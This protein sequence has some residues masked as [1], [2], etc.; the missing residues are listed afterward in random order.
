MSGAS[1]SFDQAR[2]GADGDSVFAPFDAPPATGSIQDQGRFTGVPTAIFGFIAFSVIA[3]LVVALAITPG[4]AVLQIGTAA[5]TSLF[6][7]LPSYIDV[8]RL[9]QRNRIFANS[10]TGP[11]QIATVYNQ[12]RQEAS[13][14]QVS[15]YLKAAAIDG[16]DKDFYQHGGVDVPSLVRAAV[17]N[18][19]AG[20]IQSGASTIAMQVVRNVQVQQSLQLKTAAEQQA[21]YKAA[22]SDTLSRKLK[23]MKLAIGL[24]KTYSKKEILLAYL[25]IANFGHANYGVEAAAQAYFSTTAASLTP[26]QAASII[27]IVQSPSARNLGTPSDYAAN[28]VRRNFILRQMHDDGDITAAQ[29][30]TALATKVDASFVHTSIVSDSCLQ[31]PVDFRWMCDYVVHDVPDI[32]AFGSTKAQRLANWKLGGYDVYTTLNTAMQTVATNTLHSYVP[33]TE[34]QFQLGGAVSTVQPGTGDILVM[35]ENKDFNDTLAG[36]GRG[37]TAVNYNTD[38]DKGGA[39]GFQPGSSYKLFTLLAWLEAGKGLNSVFNASVRSIAMSRFTDSC[40]SNGGPPYTFTNDENE[41]GP[42]TILHATAQSIN[43]V[44]LQMAATLDLCT[45]KNLAVSLGVHNAN[46]S[47]LS[48]YP[49][50]VIGGCN[51]TIAPLTMAA[52]YAAIADKGIYCSPVAVAKIIGPSGRNLGGEKANCHQAIPARIANTAATALQG[53]M[54]PFG[55]GATA[56]PN[57]GTPFL[58]KTGTTNNS[59]QTWIVSSSTKAATAVWIGNIAGSQPL[60]AVYVG[61]IQ[62]ALL[63]HI[64]FKTIMRYVDSRLGRGAAFPPPDP[65]LMGSSPTGYFAPPVA[66]PKKKAPAPPSTP[67]PVVPPAPGG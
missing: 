56:N 38:E 34:T 41:Q 7:S 11:V 20:S 31:A 6:T 28:E 29:L 10:P 55:T 42:T 30:K 57:D 44:F 2:R 62:A 32:T 64:V 63:R 12:N 4:L 47:P 59:L 8:G 58:G 1:S 65:S 52:A 3:G 17:S 24:E 33:K 49:S 15:P 46:G 36:G 23:E 39:V 19:N 14:S 25:N 40:G 27:A 67:P 54:G 37:T 43:S 13:W 26:A 61:G 5:S 45:I 35:A 50:C 21:A 51:N 22:T 16:E 48:T 9:P 53:V 60:R 18:A 66:P